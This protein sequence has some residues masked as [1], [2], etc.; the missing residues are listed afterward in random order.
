MVRPQLGLDGYLEGI[1]SVSKATD[2]GLEG[3]CAGS[4]EVLGSG[5]RV[6]K[7]FHPMDQP[8]L[9]GC[10]FDATG[11]I[12]KDTNVCISCDAMDLNK[13]PVLYRSQRECPSD[14]TRSVEVHL[15]NGKLMLPFFLITRG[16]SK[17][18]GQVPC[19]TGNFELCVDFKTETSDD[20]YAELEGIYNG[21]DHV[22]SDALTTSDPNNISV[23][24]Q[25]LQN[26]KRRDK[27]GNRGVTAH[28]DST[29]LLAQA[30]HK[31][32]VVNESKLHFTIDLFLPNFAVKI[33]TQLV[34]A[35]NRLEVANTNA[36]KMT[37]STLSAATV[38]SS[39]MPLSAQLQLPTVIQNVIKNLHKVSLTS[40]KEDSVAVGTV[41]LSSFFDVLAGTQSQLVSPHSEGVVTKPS[42][43]RYDTDIDNVGMSNWEIDFNCV[44]KNIQF[45]RNA[46]LYATE[47][48]IAITFLL[49]LIWARRMDNRDIQKLCITALAGNKPADECLYEVIVRTGMRRRAGT[50]STVCIQV[51]EERGGTAPFTL[52]DPHRKVLQRGNVDR[53]LL[54]AARLVYLAVA[55]SDVVANL[56]N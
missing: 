21:T 4:C 9:G 43:M 18:C 45:E 13:R 53:F 2:L 37:V 36:L 51:N 55:R 54:A 31:T 5:S 52:R 46:T 17:Y 28:Q 44:F 26:N 41:T 3:E 47:I 24:V 50:T 15:Q 48:A 1:T 8:V 14:R 27:G 25:S 7:R 29:A 49:L 30:T 42:D 38:T 32:Y 40:S 19:V 20:V 34:E 23:T 16:E 33:V 39:D 6:C 11:E 35:L 12:T 56:M 22:L 10:H